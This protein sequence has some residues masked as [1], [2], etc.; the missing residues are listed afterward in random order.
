MGANETRS[1]GAHPVEFGALAKMA[2]VTVEDFAISRLMTRRAAKSPHA[3]LALIDSCNAKWVL[4]G[5]VARHA[6]GLE[7]RN[8]QVQRKEEYIH[9]DATR[10]DGRRMMASRTTD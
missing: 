4:L 6:R 9:K 10:S 2:A 8:R 7:K 5:R 1:A 3:I